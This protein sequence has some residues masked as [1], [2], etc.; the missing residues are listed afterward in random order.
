MCRS[1]WELPSVHEKRKLKVAFSVV[2][3]DSFNKKIQE[4]ISYYYSLRSHRN[5]VPGIQRA[6]LAA[7]EYMSSTDKAPRHDLR[8]E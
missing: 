7:L 3:V 6:V 2:R 8:P 5:D 1:E 4:I